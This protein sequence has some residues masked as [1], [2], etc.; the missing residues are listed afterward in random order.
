MTRS[1]RILYGATLALLLGSPPGA[2]AQSEDVADFERISVTGSRIKR[3][4]VEGPS[5]VVTITSD[6]MQ[7]R[8]YT[9]VLEALNDLSQNAG[10]GIDQQN[11]FGFTP[12]ASAVDIRG[13]GVGRTLVLIDGRRVPVFP[14]ASGGT[15][16]FVDLSSIPTAAIDRVEVLT[17]GA[18]AIY[19][20]DAISGVV[21]I[22]L[23]KDV[24]ATS[25]NLRAGDTFGG[26]ADTLRAQF[27]HGITTAQ[28]NILLFAEYLD[29]GEFAFSDRSYSASDVL[30]GVGGAGPGIF[31]S[32]GT[33]GTFRGTN[34]NVPSADCLDQNPGVGVINGF[35]RFN[36]AAFRQLSSP[37][38]AL[39]F[40]AHFDQQINDDITGF[41]RFSF[42]TSETRTEIEPMFFDEGADAQI[43]ANAPNNPTS[44]FNDPGGVIYGGPQAGTFRRRLVE[45]GPRSSTIDNDTYSALAGLRGFLD[46]GYEWELGVGY[47]EQR[48]T[49]LRQGFASRSAIN[50]AIFGTDTDGDGFGDTGTLNLFEPISAA[51][52]ASL[53]TEPR[54]DG[55]SS[56]GSIDLQVNGDLFDMPFGTAQIAGVLEFNR[57]RFSDDRDPDTFNGNVIA[58]GGA[59]GGG[60]RNYSAFG[61]ELALPLLEDLRVNVAG[62]YDNY[63]DESSVGGSF[64]PRVALEYRPV[65]DLLVRASAGESFRAPDLQRLFGATTNGFSDLVDTPQCLQDGGTGRGDP[66]VLSCTQSVQSVETVTGSNI[67][68]TE[69]EGSNAGIGVVYQAM[70]NL[71]LSADYF[72][73]KLENIVNTPSNQFILD[74]NAADGSF[75]NA[76]VRLGSEVTTLNPGGLDVVSSQARNLSFQRVQGVDLSARYDF[77]LD[78]VGDF[79]ATFGGTYIDRFEIQELPGEDIVPVLSQGTLG[80][81]VRFKANANLRWEKGDYSATVF[82]NFVGAFTPDDTSS[83]DRVSSWTTWNVTGTWNTPWNSQLLVGVNN[84]F[85]N[86]PPLDLSDGNNSQP[87][88]N[89]FFHDALGSTAYLEY[90]QSF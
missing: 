17:D 33:P 49:S 16:N 23:R 15:D 43:S 78:S 26:G 86:D 51:T 68:L 34:G 18:S 63:E 45:F 48:I 21:N 60:S 41:G 85:D 12:S 90:R 7:K 56:V 84:L 76:I 62:R 57:Q 67:D 72:Y 55:L 28:G 64:S 66:N 19:G 35:C 52:V 70:D 88:Y 38:E 6:D 30:G 69:E 82:G 32:G 58:L 50:A 13:F 80:E 83:I 36:R 27:S 37:Y 40:A 79:S 46:N 31:S 1:A 89:Q 61:V 71:T 54:T 24:D 8:G 3:I 10:G 5:P 42:Y 25:V 73:V 77:T 14:L 9:T 74:S 59:G 2:L 75:A 87:F 65:Q 53:S 11:S 29:V 81:Y 39:S 4:D 47:T 22:I 20:S 44:A